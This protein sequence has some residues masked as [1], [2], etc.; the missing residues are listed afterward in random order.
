VRRIVLYIAAS[1]DGYIARADGSLDWLDAAA[2]AGED[3]GYGEFLSTCDTLLVGGVTFRQLLGSGEYPYAGKRV[4]VFTR[5]GPVD[6]P[7]GAEV[8]FVDSDPAELARRLLDEP[9]DDIWLVG[10]S[11]VIQP[12]VDAGLVDEIILSVIPVVLG[13][14]IH[15]FA[16]G[17]LEKR[18]ELLD[19]RS[20]PGG[21]VQL[22]YRPR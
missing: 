17:T 14:G 7:E 19:E 21:I 16:H 22:R 5:Q 8:E 6:V 11:A 3:Y 1:L 2:V 15:L 9:G 13:E 18:L 4:Y 10:G 20:Y 12:V